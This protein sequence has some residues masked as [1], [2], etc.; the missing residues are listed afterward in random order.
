MLLRKNHHSERII[1]DTNNVIL[2][3]AGLEGQQHLFQFNL[4]YCRIKERGLSTNESIYQ[5]RPQEKKSLNLIKTDSGRKH[6][7]NKPAFMSRS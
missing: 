7:E 6:T 4:I 2:Q 1:R 5:Q 3:K